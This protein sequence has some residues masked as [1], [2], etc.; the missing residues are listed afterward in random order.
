[1]ARLRPPRAYFSLLRNWLWSGRWYVATIL[2]LVAATIGATSLP[3]LDVFGKCREREARILGWLLQAIGFLILA[4]GYIADAETH[5]RL[6]PKAWLVN[7]PSIW[8][9]PPITLHANNI[10]TGAAV[11][12]RVRIT[13]A[14]GPEATETE[15]IAALERNVSVLFSEVDQNSSEVFERIQKLRLEFDTLGTS[16]NT[17]ITDV[18]STMVNAVSGRVQLNL[19]AVALFLF[20]ITVAS[21]SPEI[22]SMLGYPPSCAGALFGP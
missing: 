1:M 5:H 6:T 13:Q 21:L 10:L 8:V 4:Q 16:L 7:M 15:R 2:I 14:V 17:Q 18:N 12:G 19:F 11:L 9:P 20:G 22:A 3:E